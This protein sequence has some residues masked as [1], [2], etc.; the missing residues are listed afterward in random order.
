MEGKEDKMLKSGLPRT[1]LGKQI[2]DQ[3][4]ANT[5]NAVGD[6][7][8]FLEALD[9]DRNGTISH[10]DI[11]QAREHHIASISSALRSLFSWSD[12]CLSVILR[13]DRNGNGDVTYG[14]FFMEVEE[15]RARVADG[16]ASSTVDFLSSLDRNRDGKISHADIVLARKENMAKINAQLTELFSLSDFCTYFIWHHDRDGNGEVSYAE[17]LKE[18]AEGRASI[19]RV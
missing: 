1:T 19:T 6:I 15:K 17:F 13:H 16:K 10:A 5:I 9:L 18:I 8:G 4:N 3:Q 14:E 7:V 11:V 12:L 2:N